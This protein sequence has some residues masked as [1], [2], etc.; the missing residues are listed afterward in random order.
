MLTSQG[1]GAANAWRQEAVPQQSTEVMT[2]DQVTAMLQEF[3]NKRIA[4]ASLEDTFAFFDA[5]KFPQEGKA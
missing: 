5:V 4:G 3:Y 2:M 1:R